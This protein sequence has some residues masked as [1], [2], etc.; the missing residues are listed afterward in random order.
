ML[1]NCNSAQMLINYTN[2]WIR[3]SGLKI[4]T[5]GCEQ[6]RLC[7]RLISIQKLLHF[8]F[9]LFTPS[10]FT[11]LRK[12][13][14]IKALPDPNM[15]DLDLKKILFKIQFSRG[16]TRAFNSLHRLKFETVDIASHVILHIC[17]ESIFS[18][19]KLWKT[20]ESLCFF[21]ESRWVVLLVT[22]SCFGY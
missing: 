18:P 19:I 20:S 15:H 5:L 3:T 21:C 9:L 16:V 11:W 6:S 2:G 13:F 12:Q 22:E 14:R 17:I 1:K 10:I 8:Y 7:R 4:Y